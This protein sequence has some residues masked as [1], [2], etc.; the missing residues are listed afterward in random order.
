MQA[1]NNA[2]LLE[3]VSFIFVANFCG[4][5][6]WKSDKFQDSE[7]N[8]STFRNAFANSVGSRSEPSIFTHDKILQNSHTQTN[9]KNGFFRIKSAYFSGKELKLGHFYDKN[10]LSDPNTVVW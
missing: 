8:V 3:N 7:Q 5:F 9:K 10:V 1:K 2:R 6:G 4:K